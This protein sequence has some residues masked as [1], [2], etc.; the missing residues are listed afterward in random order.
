MGEGPGGVGEGGVGG[1]ALNGV[2]QGISPGFTFFL[3]SPNLPLRNMEY[4]LT[5]A[6]FP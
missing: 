5:V 6:Y 3:L 1:G 2:G 4:F